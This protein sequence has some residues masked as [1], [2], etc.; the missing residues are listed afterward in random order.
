MEMVA[1][2]QEG[3]S[4]EFEPKF[5]PEDLL[6]LAAGNLPA[7]VVSGTLRPDGLW[8]SFRKRWDP[9]WFSI[10]EGISFLFWFGI[11]AL[12]DSGVLR[13]RKSI[14]GFLIARS[15][16]AAFL[17]LPGIA[18]VGSRLEVLCWLAF[19]VYVLAVSLRWAFCKLQIRV[20][21]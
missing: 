1:Y 19:G 7:M 13:I 11:G 6:F 10:H 3:G 15:C 8:V 14:G 21:F 9:A 12:L 16:F 4:V 17:F 2:F 18:R 5:E 20:Q